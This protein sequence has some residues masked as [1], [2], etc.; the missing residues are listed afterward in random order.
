MH[1]YLSHCIKKKK[2]SW[3]QTAVCLPSN[4]E[5]SVDKLS[6]V[7]TFIITCSYQD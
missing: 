5:M 4:S 6:T 2:G 3:P 1:G 7:F